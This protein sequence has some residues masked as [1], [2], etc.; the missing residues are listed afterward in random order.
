MKLRKL[1]ISGV[2]TVALVISST[3]AFADET[4]NDIPTGENVIED[5]ILEPVEEIT[6]DEFKEITPVISSVSLKDGKVTVKWTAVEGADGYI[7]ERKTGKDGTYS[8]I[9]EAGSNKL[10]M[11]NSAVS[12]GNTYWYRVRAMKDFAGEKVY[13]K[14]STEKGKTLSWTKDLLM[15]KKPTLKSA[16]SNGAKSIRLTWSR[17]PGVSGYQV[18]RATSKDGK[19]TKITT[20]KGSTKVTYL[21]LNR[22]TGK[23][24]WYKIRAYKTINGKVVSSKY[25]AVLSAKPT[26]GK[27]KGLEEIQTTD[28][29]SFDYQ[30]DAVSGADGYDMKISWKKEGSS[31]WSSW[32]TKA[33]DNFEVTRPIYY[34]TNYYHA[35]KDCQGRAWAAQDCRT[36]R[37]KV[38][39]YKMVNGKKEYGPWSDIV[40]TK[41]NLDGNKL[42]EE[43]VAYI[44]ETYPKFDYHD[45]FFDGEKMHPDNAS[46]FAWGDLTGVS[47]Y[48]DY[49]EAYEELKK[50]IDSYMTFHNGIILG[51][52]LFMEHLHKG[53][54]YKYAD[55]AQG[56]YWSAIM[57][58]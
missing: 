16:E 4:V 25:S 21:D 53:D 54:G 7:V 3:C 10:S 19:Y 23:T 35:T 30:W 51:G 46:F 34:L 52:C 43:L 47:V 9:L 42:K 41:P 27:V 18:Y 5:V 24:Y 28:G 22:T 15:A 14:Y 56:S 58:Y 26:L 49:D 57:L 8:K 48:S 55:T 17:I 11:V 31:A 40:Y 1:M 12:T 32:S 45:T 20:V 33:T 38:R 39:A 29:I 6:V 2:L 37:F 50:S 13:S 36:Y 44:K